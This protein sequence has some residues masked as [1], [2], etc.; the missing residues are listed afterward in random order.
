MAKQGGGD[1]RSLPV[2]LCAH[3]VRALLSTTL[4]SGSALADEVSG[5]RSE[6]LDGALPRVALTMRSSHAE[7]VVRRTVW[8]GAKRAISML[9]GYLARWRACRGSF[10]HDERL[11]SI[12]AAAAPRAGT[13]SCGPADR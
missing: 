7:L 12:R 2:R 1:Q 6:L 8:N 11:E 13:E 4:V 10:R 9:A 5:L 3:G